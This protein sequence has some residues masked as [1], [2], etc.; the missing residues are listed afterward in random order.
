MSWRKVQE[1][2]LEATLS[3]DEISAFRKSADFEHDPVEAQ[4]RQACA[5]VRS[6]IRSGG[7][8]RP[9]ADESTLPESLISP[10]MDYLRHQI[11]TR[12]NVVVNE[13]RTRAYEQ[14]LKLFD[15]IR[16]GRFIPESDAA[17]EAA[18]T[19]AGSPGYGSPNP[20][21]RLLD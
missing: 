15:E 8:C 19:P 17:T 6:I 13:S 3:Q 9:A 7:K 11:L 1:C 20:E 18:D 5:Y 16:S 21:K 10:A 14:A 2:D 12:M 4:L